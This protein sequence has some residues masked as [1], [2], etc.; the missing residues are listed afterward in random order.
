MGDVLWRWAQRGVPAV[1]VLVLVAGVVAAV[2]GWRRRRRRGGGGGGGRGG[3][4]FC[5]AAGGAGLLLVWGPGGAGPPPFRFADKVV[6]ATIFATL[7]ATGRLAEFDVPWQ[8][9]EAAQLEN[10]VGDAPVLTDDHAPV[11]QLLTPYG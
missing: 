6:H 7:A 10:F 2:E 3:R 5:G 11:D 4:A 1:V 9:A 8:V